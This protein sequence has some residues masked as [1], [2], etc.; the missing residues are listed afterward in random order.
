MEVFG[1]LIILAGVIGIVI[2]FA[3]S[4]EN[5]EDSSRPQNGNQ[6]SQ[7]VNTNNN[8]IEQ[9]PR[10]SNKMD[11]YFSNVPNDKRNKQIESLISELLDYADKPI[12]IKEIPMLVYGEALVAPSRIRPFLMLCSAYAYLYCC[13]DIK[14][15]VGCGELA[16]TETDCYHKDHCIGH[17]KWLVREEQIA[18]RLFDENGYSKIFGNP[19]LNK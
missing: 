1:V 12:E 16:L 18:S 10:S 7:S 17:Y 8:R 4:K 13:N 11:K 14:H 9:V 6:T 19:L 3:K 2:L 15:A 5:I